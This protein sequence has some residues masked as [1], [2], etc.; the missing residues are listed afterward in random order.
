MGCQVPTM[1]YR[2]EYFFR[3]KEWWRKKQLP[4]KRKRPPI[5]NLLQGIQHE[6]EKKKQ[7]MMGN[8][9]MTDTTVGGHKNRRTSSRKQLM[10]YISWA[11]ALSFSETFPQVIGCIDMLNLLNRGYFW[12]SRRVLTTANDG[13]DRDL[14]LGHFSVE[15]SMM[16]RERIASRLLLTTLTSVS[17]VLRCLRVHHSK[18]VRHEPFAAFPH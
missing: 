10:M 16:L 7:A 17:Y 9:A 5:S 14:K 2:R 1:Y 6:L 3:Q 13:G 8:Q 11:F 4:W 15:K 12:D 18:A